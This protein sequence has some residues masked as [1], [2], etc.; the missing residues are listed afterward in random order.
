MEN[1]KCTLLLDHNVC[2]PEKGASGS[3]LED[4]KDRV[5]CGIDIYAP[6]GTK[7]AA[8]EEGIVVDIGIMTSQDILPYWNETFYVTVKTVSGV[9]CK[10]AELEEISVDLHEKVREGAVI[11]SVGMVLNPEKIDGTAPLYIQDLK[12]KNPSMLH[13]ELWNKQPCASSP[14]YLGGNW[15]RE[16]IPEGLQDPEPYI[17]DKLRK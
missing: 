16:G 8:I 17:E 9:F 1:N 13:F 3:F 7:V 12:N 10:Y 2:L 11:G 6:A 15:F 5:H 14:D 4:R